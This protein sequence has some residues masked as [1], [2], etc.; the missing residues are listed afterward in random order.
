MPSWTRLL[1]NGSSGPDI[2]Q[3]GLRGPYYDENFGQRRPATAVTPQPSAGSPF[4]TV[5]Q[6]IL[7]S[8]NSIRQ[9]HTHKRSISG[10]LPSL[11]NRPRK[12]TDPDPESIDVQSA[13]L[14][15]NHAYSETMQRGKSGKAKPLEVET[16]EGHCATCGT[17][18]KWPS[19]VT[20]FRC[21]T[22]LMINDLQPF[23]PKPPAR[24][25]QAGSPAP[26]SRSGTNPGLLQNARPP[27]LNAERVKHII[28]RSLDTFFNTFRPRQPPAGAIIPSQATLNGISVERAPSHQLANQTRSAV[29]GFASSPPLSP[30]SHHLIPPQA[31][32]NGLRRSSNSDAPDARPQFQ[33][34][35]NSSN[36]SIRRKPVPP[37]AGNLP[38][39]AMR[40]APMPPPLTSPR[41]LNIPPDSNEVP[42]RSR[43]SGP[44]D[45]D[46]ARRLPTPFQ[47]LEDYILRSFS[48]H[49][50][51]NSSFLRV[52][53]RM[54]PSA[55]S[56]DGLVPRRAVTSPPNWPQLPEATISDLDAKMLLLGN[57]AENSS[58][59]TSHEETG[60]E[61]ERRATQGTQRDGQRP[62]VHSKS[63][64]INW[65]ELHD[66]YDTVLNAGL[67]WRGRFQEHQQ[68]TNTSG[69]SFEDSEDVLRQMD[70]ILSDGRV[71]LHRTLL[72]ASENLLKRPG[73]PLKDSQDIRF[74]LILLAN[75]LMY[76]KGASTQQSVA[77]Q[78]MSRTRSR[79]FNGLACHTNGMGGMMPLASGKDREQV[80]A[81]LKRVFGLLSN[82]SSQCHR[83]LTAWF[84][85][86]DE[87]R[88]AELVDLVQSFVTRRL[89]RQHGRHRSN[90]DDNPTA[91]L[92]PNLSGTHADT[93]A[94]LHAALG[95]GSQNKG[96][97]ENRSQLPSYMEDWQVKAAAKLMALLFAANKSFHGQRSI[98]SL[99]ADARMSR[100]GSLS[101]T[102]IKNYGQSLST[103]DF[104]NSMVDLHDLVLDFECW[105]TTPS[106][107]S[108][109]QYPFFLS[110]GSKI[111]IMEHDAKR[112]MDVRAREA[113]FNNILKNKSIE[114]YLVLKVRRDCLV[115]DSLKSISEVVGAGQQDIKKGLKV[116][117]VNEEGIDAGGLRKEWFL[118]LVREIFDPRQ[119]MFLYDDESQFCYFNPHSFETS[120]QYFL[121]GAL[122]GLAIYNS[123]ILD[124]ALPPF[125]FKKLLASGPPHATQGRTPYRYTLKDLAEYRPELARGLRRL[126]EFDGDV[127][128]TFCRDFVIEIERYGQVIQVPLC[129]NG[130]RRP[131]TESN[132]AEFVE[133]YVR[134]LLDTQVSRQYEPFKRGFFTVCGGNALS[135]FQPEE[136]ELLVRGSDEPLDVPSLKAVAVYENWYQGPEHSSTK[137]PSP[138]EQVPLLQWFWSSFEQATPGDQRKLLGF[139]TGSDRIPAV[140]A[141][142][143]VIKVAFGGPDGNR[144]PIART[145]FN[146]LLLYGYRTAGELENKLWTAVGGSEGFGLK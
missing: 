102:Y 30:Q 145:C 49:E 114:Q 22:C 92:I 131:V 143:L 67:H 20:E 5:S 121:V 117:F 21:T 50:C 6:T 3:S 69:K 104:Y 83:H 40:N 18:V 26:V 15:E 113:F 19:S 38:E 89:K 43:S 39:R 8:H 134:Y 86:Y 98:K 9:P 58:W 24:P 90:P 81:I 44:N 35:P 127:Q 118:L 88:L 28:D 106:R 65:R 56:E 75:P 54:E 25:V 14:S 7:P 34:T 41:L 37:P 36:S 29:H 73:R 140:G 85:R 122:L 141:T 72:K 115:E 27:P 96:R 129:D 11:L 76:L 94:Q 111:R 71:R 32:G 105:E 107:F 97:I 139:I 146:Q 133:L 57:V 108:F 120:D 116:H 103:S 84:S 112:Q 74:L 10:T 77:A 47:A 101:R 136:I 99:A 63:P 142:N 53:P 130:A 2:S 33:D 13:G 51:V 55:R 17:L 61:L 52:R 60:P 93:S 87:E 144:L 124:V 59:W 70:A 91:G 78:D 1:A 62:M 126:L 68:K 119:G 31:V 23:R 137:I 138:A 64:S 79:S 45:L 12:K 100:P 128:A 48:D 95:L 16:T 4:P 110:V 123:T 80:Y 109:C 66:W 125:T 132:R 42:Q 82:V 46:G 135:L